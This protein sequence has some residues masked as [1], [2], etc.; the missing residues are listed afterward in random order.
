MNSLFFVGLLV[1]LMVG[2]ILL[3]MRAVKKGAKV[4]KAIAVQVASFCLMFGLCFG[5]TAIV[6]NAAEATTDQNTSQTT[7]SSNQGTVDYT[8][9][10]KAIAMS[11][12]IGAGCIGAG[13]AVA[14]AAPAAI[15]AISENPAN[16]GNSLIFV[17]LAE[18]ISIIGL[19][20]AIIIKLV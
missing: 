11:I 1:V 4:K 12:A 7:A 3:A 8:E 20:I 16:V 13:L 9:A 5:A 17:G 14:A 18:G 15:G 10:I 2:S 19:I 6:A